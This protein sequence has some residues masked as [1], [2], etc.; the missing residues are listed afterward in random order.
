LIQFQIVGVKF[1]SERFPNFEKSSLHSF[2]RRVCTKLVSNLEK[3]FELFSDFQMLITPAG[4]TR[5][6]RVQLLHDL[7]QNSFE[8]PVRSK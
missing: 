4:I 6:A 2:W 3:S 5:R 1:F 7:I 8:M